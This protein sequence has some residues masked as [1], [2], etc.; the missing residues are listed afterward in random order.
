MAARSTLR[1]AW[2]N[3]W[4]NRRRT[5][6]AVAAIGLAAALVLAYHSLVRAYAVWIV[7]TLTGPML[8]HVQIH[9]L[10]WRKDRAMD[11]T[12]PDVASLL[13]SVRGDPDTA[14]ATARIYAPALAALGE[15]GFAVVVLGVDWEEESRPNRLLSGA[16]RPRS[17]GHALIGRM[18][19]EMMGV[20]VGDQI[21]LVGQGV[22]GSLANDLFRIEGLVQTPVDFVNRQG[23]LLELGEAQTLFAMPDEAHEIVVHSRDP[24]GA[25]LLASRL[26]ALPALAEAEVLDWQTIAPEMLSLIQILEVAGIFALVLIFVAA[27][28]GVANTMLMATFERTHELGM[29]LALGAAPGRIVGMILVES[30]ALGLTGA[31]LGGTL[32]VVFVAVTHETG[33]DFAALT[34]G[35]PSELSF[36]GLSWSMRFYP[37]LAPADLGR[38]VLAVV[39]TSLLASVWP[40]LR[41]AR[42]EPSRALRD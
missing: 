41:A 40:A 39:L 24:Q 36:A 29:L 6:L 3:L 20:R 28:A 13:E 8:G 34:G 1:I 21:A 10:E 35:G 15:E 38:T 33:L 30:V 22:D 7:D 32:G 37:T 31:A 12:L 4:R 9:A 23:I 19:A 26:A 18:L 16:P 27:A 11:R 2:R 5:G 14:S 42:L 25:K 17:R